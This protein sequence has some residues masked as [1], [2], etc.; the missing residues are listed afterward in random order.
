MG[1]SLVI[2]CSGLSSGAI[3]Y[4]M[5][6]FSISIRIWTVSQNTKHKMQYNM[7]QSANRKWTVS[8]RQ[9]HCNELKPWMISERQQRW[10]L[11]QNYVNQGVRC[12][13]VYNGEYIQWGSMS[14]RD[15]TKM[16]RRIEGITLA[17]R[18]MHS[19]SVRIDLQ[20]K[21]NIEQW[22]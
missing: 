5:T 17:T 18:K 7:L 11:H 10:I 9:S 2:K 3:G 12:H 20:S 21:I 4:Q 8:Y 14:T 22:L 16:D 1:S 15:T 19:S 6:N 13:P